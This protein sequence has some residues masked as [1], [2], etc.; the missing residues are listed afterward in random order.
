M[1]SIEEDAQIISLTNFIV[2]ERGVQL[3]TIPL[4]TATWTWRLVDT[5]GD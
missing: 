5:F 4:P 3:H 1:D 2:P